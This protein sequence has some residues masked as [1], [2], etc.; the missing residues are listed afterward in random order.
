MFVDVFLLKKI[1][2]GELRKKNALK[3]T[4]ILL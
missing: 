4:F 1:D 3:L 2:E